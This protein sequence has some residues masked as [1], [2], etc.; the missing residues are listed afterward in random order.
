MRVAAK[1]TSASLFKSPVIPFTLVKDKKKHLVSNMD[2]IDWPSLTESELRL[3]SI[4]C[5]NALWEEEKE[6]NIT[7]SDIEPGFYSYLSK[8]AYS[9]TDIKHIK[10]LKEYVLNFSILVTGWL[11]DNGMINPEIERTFTNKI[12]QLIILGKNIVEEDKKGHKVPKK[13]IQEAMKN[14]LSDIIGELQGFED[15]LKQ[16]LA[17]LVASY[18]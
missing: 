18:V 5:V 12:N 11:L 10:K 15:E 14:K 4:K 8:K 17:N 2:K 16:P 3:Q 7:R 13:N 9:K 6:G 1:T